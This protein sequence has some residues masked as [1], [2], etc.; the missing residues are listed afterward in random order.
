MCSGACRWLSFRSTK[1]KNFDLCNSSVNKARSVLCLHNDEMPMVN[2][3]KL[4]RFNLL[5]VLE[6]TSPLYNK[7]VY[8]SFEN[9]SNLVLLEYLALMSNRLISDNAVSCNGASSLENLCHLNQLEALTIEAEYAIPNSISLPG[10]NAF[11]CNLRKLKLSKTYLPWKDIA[12]I[13]LLPGL[14]MLK[15]KMDAFYGPEWEPIEGGFRRLKFLLLENTD[16]K[17]WNAFDDEFP[18]LEHL[19]LKHCEKLEGIP[20]V[21]SNVTTLKSI[22]LE[23]CGQDLSSCAKN[24]QQEHL[25]YGNN[26]LKVLVRNPQLFMGISAFQ[27]ELPFR[28]Y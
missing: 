18:I 13:A 14:E 5:R 16:L 17:I 28:L 1:P 25:D 11:P 10:I 9:L 24:I 23:W 7:G 21:F 2:D 27:S 3:P 15:L 12:K 19:V 22:D 8:M 4:V 6:L 26:E 20:T